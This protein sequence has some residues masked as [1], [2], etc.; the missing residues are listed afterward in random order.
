M[1]V[2]CKCNHC[3]QPI[4]FPSEMAG[5]AIECPNCKI[6]TTLFIPPPPEKPATPKNYIP[7]KKADGNPNIEKNIEGIGRLFFVLGLIGLV[8]GGVEC[9]SGKDALGALFAVISFFQGC[10]FL[11]LFSALAEIIRLLRKLVAK[12]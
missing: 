9:V 4:E 8:G 7:D 1:T 6:E 10:I 3:S 11:V 5:Q 12:P 2:K